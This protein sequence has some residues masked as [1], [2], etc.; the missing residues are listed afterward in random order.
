MQK[1]DLKGKVVQKRDNALL[2]KQK[3]LMKDIPNPINE[4]ESKLAKQV[5]NKA[6]EDMNSQEAKE[7][8]KPSTNKFNEIYDAMNHYTKEEKHVDVHEEKSKMGGGHEIHEDHDRPSPS[9]Y[10]VRKN[11]GS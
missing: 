8:L 3:N 11:Q 7:L 5:K 6:S 2:R 4:I 1:A 9:N 10:D